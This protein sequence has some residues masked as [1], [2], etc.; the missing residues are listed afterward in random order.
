MGSRCLIRTHL[1]PEGSVTKSGREIMEIL[2]AYDL[3]GC[4]H[5]A[6]QL[7][8][9]DRKTV[10]RYVALR[11]AG[12]DPA[13][14]RRRARAVD[15]FAAKV[16]ELVDRSSGKIRADVVHRRLTAMGSQGSERSTRRAVA[17]AKA[18]W[19]A[20]RRRTCR[21]WIPERGMWLQ[22]DWG[23]ARGSVAGGRSCSAAG[24][25]GRGSGLSCHPGIRVWAA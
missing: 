24:W 23:E 1:G 3:T 14:Q 5:S 16:E 18:A 15:E 17:E 4:A 20:G 19:Q 8:G 12:D 7:A 9:T 10:L 21:P 6:A 11:E 25:R 13:E 22:W 2:E